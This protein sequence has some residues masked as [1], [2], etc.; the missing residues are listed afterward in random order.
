[1]AHLEQVEQYI[2][3]HLSKLSTS[4]QHLSRSPSYI[5]FSTVLVTRFDARP[6]YRPLAKE[7]FFQWSRGKMLWCC[8]A[9]NN[10]AVLGRTWEKHTIMN[11]WFA[12]NIKKYFSVNNTM[13]TTR[14]VSYSILADN[15]RLNVCK[16][17]CLPNHRWAIGQGHMSNHRWAE[18]WRF[19]NL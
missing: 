17:L 9:P 16:T 15:W 5:L 18:I 4:I 3:V 6:S 2:P 14:K 1:M 8:L 7:V 11:I 10:W 12:V 19:D 13:L